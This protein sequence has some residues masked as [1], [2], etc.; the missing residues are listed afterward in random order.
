MTA[1][2]DAESRE[3]ARAYGEETAWE[4]AHRWRGEHIRFIELVFNRFDKDGAWP[5]VDGFQRA[6][7]QQAHEVN[8]REL[9]QE[10]PRELGFLV[11]TGTKEVI[12]LSV[13]GIAS[14][15]QASTLL[16]TFVA[17]VRFAVSRYLGAGSDYTPRI[18]SADLAGLGN[19]PL[20]RRAGLLLEHD[21]LIFGGGTGNFTDPEWHRDTGRYIREFRGVETVEDYLA[22]QE[23]LLT[24]KSQSA[25]SFTSALQ[26][27]GVPK[28]QPST[29][30]QQGSLGA[31][32]L[33]LEDM[34][35]TI[36]EAA[37]SRLQSGHRRDAVHE[38][39]LAFRDLV[40]A[41]SGL[42]ALDGAALMSEA[43]S[44]AEPHL[45]VADLATPTG[46]AFRREPCSSLRA[47]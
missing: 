19:P 32:A 29:S 24:P 8:L 30:P 12:A 5:E 15:P 40:R 38:S 9:V 10:M 31:I 42:T 33:L 36:R 18:T 13:R 20:M 28:A 22:V 6:L 26:Q 17:I 34:H 43:F 25:R 27:F 21:T 45:L 35:P 4:L 2:M 41:R 23:R 11:G 39:A 44:L 1:Q 37:Q 47:P 46:Q 16:D 14:L 3:R 7:D